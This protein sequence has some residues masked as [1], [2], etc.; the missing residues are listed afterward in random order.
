[1]NI[2]EI[3]ALILIII[4]IILLYKIVTS[5]KE[6]ME[7]TIVS[8]KTLSQQESQQ[9]QQESQQLQQESQQKSIF[10]NTY[11]D[12]TKLLTFTCTFAGKKYYL[13]NVKSSDC[14]TT[15][16]QLQDCNAIK[17]ILIE[18]SELQTQLPVYLKTLE[19]I[20]PSPYPIPRQY[21][22]DFRVTQIISPRASEEATKSPTQ[23]TPHY[24]IMGQASPTDPSTFNNYLLYDHGINQLCGDPYLGPNKRYNQVTIIEK[25]IGGTKLSLK[26]AMKTRD[27][28][29]RINPKTKETLIVPIIDQQN[30]K[31]KTRIVYIGACK[32]VT[33]QMNNKT[34]MRLCL[35]DDINDPNVL[36][37]EPE[38]VLQTSPSTP[39][40]QTQI[41]LPSIIPST[42]S[43][44][45][46]S[47]SLTPTSS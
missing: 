32:N 24:T 37:F 41:Q 44:S 38:F 46:A 5:C 23:R 21:I 31:P 3:L 15:S 26:L 12:P 9:P 10:N 1:M 8:S 36:E 45:P 4:S 14:T 30:G 35:Y 20:S 19:T 39:T 47:T 6:K 22:T 42:L 40:T 2:S 43:T 25:S 29:T 11:L 16:P 27:I 34:Y 28:L 7:N 17:M 33:C 18:E 13:A